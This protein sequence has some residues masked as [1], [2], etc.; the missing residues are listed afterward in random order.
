MKRQTSKVKRLQEPFKILISE[1]FPRQRV[2]I[3]WD[4]SERVLPLDLQTKIDDFW[5]TELIHKPHLFNGDLCRLNHWQKKDDYLILDLGRTNYKEQWYSNAFC[6]EIKEQFGNDSPARALG[7]SAVLVSSD[8]Q[9]ILLKR[10]AEVGEDPDKFDVWG[11][12]IHPDEHAINGKPDPFC[13][14][15]TEILEEANLTLSE[16]EPLTCIGL[17]ET[18][19]TFKPEMIFRVQ[20]QL[21]AA[22]VFKLAKAYRSSEWSAL[23]SIT[24]RPESL[25]QFLQEYG[26]QTSAS[27]Y[28]ALWLH[29]NLNIHL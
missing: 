18:T 27:A 14:I 22:E 8:Q 19:T 26:E 5:S 17:I 7:V 1:T 10:S 3:N 20:I 25:R 15:A 29:G 12:H 28:G 4:A 23:M 24:N 21:R 6:R 2:K 16:D 9:I 11:G 13:A